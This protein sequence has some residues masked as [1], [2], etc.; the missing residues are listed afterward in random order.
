MRRDENYFVC[1]SKVL[2]APLK[3]S[4]SVAGDAMPDV[5]NDMY[6]F[7]EFRMDVQTGSCG[8]ARTSSH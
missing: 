6:E 2:K 1:S 3:I 5:V 4:Q 8:G 7:G